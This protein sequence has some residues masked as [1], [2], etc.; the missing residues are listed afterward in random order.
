MSA[1]RRAAATAAQRLERAGAARDYFAALH[2]APYRFDFFQTLRRIECLF[3]H[4][5]RLGEAQRP[6]D[7][8][9][10]LGQDP[11]LDFAPAAL[12]R[13]DQGDAGRRPRLQVR[14]FGLLGPNGP[15]PLHLTEYA[16]ERQLHGGDTTFARFLDVFH[17]RLL[18]LFYRA[19]A[20]AQPHVSLDRPWDERFRGWLGALIG[21]GAPQLR[22]RDA[23]GDHAKLFFAGLLG[24]QNRN[25][26]GLRGLLAGYFGLPVRIEPFVG[27]WLRLPESDRSRLGQGVGVRLGRSAVLGGRVWD[28]QHK[29][30][31]H[32]GPVGASQYE[33][34]LPGGSAL[35]PLVALV[36][37]YQGWELDWDLRL[38][39]KQDELPPLAL[40]RSGR[41]GWTSWLGQRIVR[42]DAASLTLDAERL[43]ARTAMPAGA[44][45]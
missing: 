40:A 35:A 32:L 34:F 16:R 27:H 2:A 30:R 15:L 5:P 31:I 7:E 8:P 24:R 25:A 1:V 22:D 36:R 23:A 37:Q 14:F 33:D 43:A 3:A 45:A 28:R 11:A 29:F 10:R 19:W 6:G 12:S 41:L 17:H 26:D 42:G 13:F 20:Q 9:L 4:K 38:I 39:M 21:I 18:L 44:G